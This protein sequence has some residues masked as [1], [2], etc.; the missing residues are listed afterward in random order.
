MNVAHINIYIKPL[1]HPTQSSRTKVRCSISIAIEATFTGYPPARIRTG[2]FRCIRLEQILESHS[3]IRLIGTHPYDPTP[4][5][6]T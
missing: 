2:N 1:V 6:L 4:P 3:G 5:F